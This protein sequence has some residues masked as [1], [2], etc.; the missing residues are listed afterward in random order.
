MGQKGKIYL[1]IY[2]VLA[3]S[4]S[5]EYLFLVNYCPLVVG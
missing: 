1:F 4:S 3:V 5:V 2:Q